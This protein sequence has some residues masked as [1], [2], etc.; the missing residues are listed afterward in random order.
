M[1]V[2]PNA[3]AGPA[4]AAPAAAPAA[5]EA[6]GGGNVFDD[7]AFADPGLEGAAA[8]PE[9]DPPLETGT[10]ATQVKVGEE[11]PPEGQPKEPGK[12]EPEGPKPPVVAPPRMWA[13]QYDTPEK[14]EAAH[15]QQ[16]IAYQNSSVEGRRL[17]G[18]LKD[19]QGQA[20]SDKTRIAELEAELAAGPPLKDLSKEELE[21]LSPAEQVQHALALQRQQDK[22]EEGKKDAKQRV[23][24]EERAAEELETHITASARRMAKDT[25]TFPGFSD[26]QTVRVM[27][28]ILEI[29]PAM[30]G[31]KHTAQM[32]YFASIGWQR[33]QEMRAGKDA[34]DE[35][36]RLAA[37]QAAADAA[38]V[39]A[40]K[41]GPAQISP[42]AGGSGVDPDSDEAHN[43]ALIA[44]GKRKETFS[45]L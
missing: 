19:A 43:N 34:S 10:P 2:A 38:R 20:T 30:R 16:G 7:F 44:A 21:A 6:G 24:T 4:G 14:L 17:N 33:V 36:A 31:D 35:S 22:M 13:D 39:G 1:E 15:R 41:T 25:K 28:E 26:P 12:A 11:K 37:E 8:V 27:D 3:G 5:P 23:E 40:G 45:G 42:P 32:A 18:L 29:M 9:L